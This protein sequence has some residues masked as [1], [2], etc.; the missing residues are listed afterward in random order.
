M[1]GHLALCYLIAACF[2]SICHLIVSMILLL[3]DKN[4]SE[5]LANIFD[6]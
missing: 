6:K 4:D 2:L 3:H 1:T 5:Q